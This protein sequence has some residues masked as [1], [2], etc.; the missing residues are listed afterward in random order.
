[1]AKLSFLFT[2]GLLVLWAGPLPVHGHS[3]SSSRLQLDIVAAE[4]RTL[5]LRMSLLDLVHLIDLDGNADGKLTRGEITA[6]EP[7]ILNLLLNGISLDNS[8]GHCVLQAR[9]DAVSL[10]TL[11]EA[12]ALRVVLH[13]SCPETADTSSLHLGYELLFQED[14]THRALLTVGI[15][16]RK[17][18]FLLTSDQRA[19][20]LMATLCTPALPGIRCS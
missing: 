1:M 10:A 4:P 9:E 11:E 16:A 17:A 13:P 15:N 20:T 12:P 7:E 2:L 14:P 18:Q 5:T 6:A 19:V 8:R 3:Q